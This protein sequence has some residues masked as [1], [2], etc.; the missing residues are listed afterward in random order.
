[1]KKE[2]GMEIPRVCGR[3]MGGVHLKDLEQA[4]KASAP[5]KAERP[6]VCPGQ[7]ALPAVVLDS[8]RKESQLC[9]VA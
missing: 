2:T 7:S 8:D 6:P 1:M 9:I 3:G 4:P 5:G